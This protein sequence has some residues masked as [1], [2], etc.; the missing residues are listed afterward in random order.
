MNTLAQ[1]PS[2]PATRGSGTLREGRTCCWR[3]TSPPRGR[4]GRGPH[5][6]GRHGLRRWTGG[7]RRPGSGRQR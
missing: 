2:R 6:I 7:G 4:A 3:R 1:P 5:R